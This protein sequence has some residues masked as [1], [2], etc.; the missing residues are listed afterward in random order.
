MIT[1]PTLENRLTEL[2]TE[3]Q[4]AVKSNSWR[5]KID[6]IA[7]E[8]HLTDEQTN[9][10]EL[11]TVLVTVGLVHRPE[12]ELDLVANL[13]VSDAVAKAI[14]ERI[15]REIFAPISSFLDQFEEAEKQAESETK[16]KRA[17]LPLD[18]QHALES[19]ETEQVFQQLAEK[20]KLHVDQVGVLYD[21]GEKI[22]VGEVKPNDFTNE[23]IRLS[24]VDSQT[25]NNITRDINE[26]IFKPLQQSLRALSEKK[27]SG[28]IF[29]EKL[30]GVYSQPHSDGLIINPYPPPEQRGGN[31][32]LAG[33]PGIDRP[34]PVIDDPYLEKP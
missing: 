26:S 5:S 23:F 29:D 30:S 17:G 22:L 4:N 20:Y 12:F 15:N 31:Q 18:I 33:I 1:S 10:L 8:H 25:A 32:S 27:G 21:L 6:Q 3:L 2:P 9:N 19:A 16:A 13:G 14:N 28:T 11:E 24:G 34:K 7:E